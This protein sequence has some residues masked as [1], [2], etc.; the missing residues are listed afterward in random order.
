MYWEREQ[1]ISLLQSILAAHAPG[2]F[3]A[4]V[5]QIVGDLIEMGLVDMDRAPAA[6]QAWCD[7]WN[8]YDVTREFVEKHYT[9]TDPSDLY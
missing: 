2:D 4:A 9:T 1:E 8:G 5:D 3:A 7:E 6:Q